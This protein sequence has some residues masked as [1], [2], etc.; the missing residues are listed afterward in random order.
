MRPI[1]TSAFLLVFLCSC[2]KKAAEE[3][4]HAF[5]NSTPGP[6]NIVTYAKS[7]EF[8]ELVLP[9]SLSEEWI[10]PN[11]LDI[12]ESINSY[13]DSISIYDNNSH[14]ICKFTKTT[15]FNYRGNPFTDRDKWLFQGVKREKRRTQTTTYVNVHEYWCKI[16]YDSIIVHP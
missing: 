2:S 14:L 9:N 10:N 8:T 15:T 6:L 7:S 13:L 4:G 1:L 5:F 11:T 12:L 16:E 3:L